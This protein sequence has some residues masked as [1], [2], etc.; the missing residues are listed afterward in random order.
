MHGQPYLGNIMGVR[1]ADD[2]LPKW[3][4]TL[5]KEGGA[6]DSVPDPELMLKEYSRL[7]PLDAD[8]RPVK[9][10]LQSLGLS[11]LVTKLYSQQKGVSYGL[12]Q[13]VEF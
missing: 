6:A 12:Y 11:E 9:D 8:G 3:I 13:R 10:K 5:R 2:R 7:R 1:A 4:L